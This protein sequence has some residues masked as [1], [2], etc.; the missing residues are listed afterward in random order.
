MRY[1]FDIDD[2]ISRHKN[3]DYANAEPIPQV[4]RQMQLLRKTQPEVEIILHTSRGMNSCKGDVQLAEQKNRP[5]LEKWL[6]EHDVPYDQIIFGKPLADAYIDDKAV[7]AA[8]FAMDG[9]DVKR[10]FSG[11]KVHIVGKLAI[12]ECDNAQEQAEWYELARKQGFAVPD[13]YGVQLGKLY[14]E[15]VE[16]LA[17]NAYDTI[18]DVVGLLYAFRCTEA[19]TRKND[20]EK[21]VSYV[22]ERGD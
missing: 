21:Y 22:R 8:D 17:R 14:M 3:R 9:V 18:N 20:I 13:V 11:A 10:G 15:V 1:V 7:S 5:T 16:G 12:K 4:I 6:K 19:P 2:T